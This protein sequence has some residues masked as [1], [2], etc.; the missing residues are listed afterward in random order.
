[1]LQLY[2]TSLDLGYLS[3]ISRGQ[4]EVSCDSLLL[5][6]VCCGGRGRMGWGCGGVHCAGWLVPG[7][8]GAAAMRVALGSVG[9]VQ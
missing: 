9:A 4:L 3:V 1:M 7:R 8:G 5:F 6:P 2:S